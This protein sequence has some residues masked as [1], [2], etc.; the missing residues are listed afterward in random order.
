MVAGQA[1]ELEPEVD[2]RR[3]H[4]CKTGS[5]FEAATVCGAVAAGTEGQP[6]A[7]LG[8][9]LGQAYQAADDVADIATSP[10]WLGKSTGRDFALGR[11]SVVLTMGLD[12]APPLVARLLSRA[13]SSIPSCKTEGVFR[14][15]LQTTII[16]MI[17]QRIIHSQEPAASS[18]HPS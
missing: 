18:W 5:I 7:A 12:Q 11:P 8:R 14:V 16:Q 9:N 17:Q 3:Y 13:L 15:W 6:W 4:M 10:A 2:L 1:W